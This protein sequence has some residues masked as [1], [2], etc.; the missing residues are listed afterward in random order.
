MDKYF[1]VLRNECRLD[2]GSAATVFP[3]SHC[4]DGAAS[5]CSGCLG[6][7]VLGGPPAASSGLS[8]AVSSGGESHK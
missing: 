7:D 3:F 8:Y 5:A 4:F 2:E 1:S 6:P